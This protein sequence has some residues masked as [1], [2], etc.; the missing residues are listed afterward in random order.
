MKNTL[1]IINSRLED[2]E[3]WVSDLEDKVVEVS[4]LKQQKQKQIYKNEDFKGPLG[5]HQI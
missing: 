5:Q 2:A 3:E 4:Q 1:E